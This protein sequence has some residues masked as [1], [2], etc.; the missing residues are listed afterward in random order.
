MPLFGLA[1][2]PNNRSDDQKLSDALHKLESEDPC[3]VFEHD[4]QAN[5]TVIRGLGDL[6][7]ADS[8][9][10][11]GGT[12]QCPCGDTSTQ[13]PLQGNHQRTGI[14][15]RPVV[16]ASSVKSICVLPLSLGVKVLNSSTR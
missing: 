3:L 2:I 12:L 7:A 14:R 16:Q 8:A 6:Q 13:H 1:L 10:A 5:E 15:S 9:G 4:T 11:A